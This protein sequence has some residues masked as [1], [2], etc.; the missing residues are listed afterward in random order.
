MLQ[1]AA[2]Y[3]HGFSKKKREEGR[4]TNR[5][6]RRKGDRNSVSGCRERKGGRGAKAEE[7]PG[8][9]GRTALHSHQRSLPVPSFVDR[10]MKVNESPV[11][12]LLIARNSSSALRRLHVFSTER[13][14]L[15][16][17]QEK[18]FLAEIQRKYEKG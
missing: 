11:W 15:F 2:V 8:A 4:K 16:A 5:E 14:I 10:S 6:K 1:C 3:V 7:S 9:D 13:K 17:R 12:A 18:L